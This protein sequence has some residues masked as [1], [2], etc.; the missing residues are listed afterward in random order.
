MS[1]AGEALNF[2]WK[3]Q[4]QRQRQPKVEYVLG[5]PV[6]SFSQNEHFENVLKIEMPLYCMF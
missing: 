5:S 1:V 2:E 4:R 3:R 6:G